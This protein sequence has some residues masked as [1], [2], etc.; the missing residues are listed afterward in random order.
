MTEQEL[1][2]AIDRIGRTADGE[3]LYLWLQKRLLR[4]V[5]ANDGGTLRV[6]NGQRILAS[7]LM[8]LLSAGIADTHAGSQRPERGT[9]RAIV[10][11]VAGPVDT[12]RNIGAARRGIPAGGFR[13]SDFDPNTPGA[14]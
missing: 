14:A 4:V 1:R 11:T 10:F 6:E 9:E 2:E 3:L 12:R 8:G 7:E 5:H 13:D